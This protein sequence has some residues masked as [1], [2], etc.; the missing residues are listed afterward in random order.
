MKIGILTWESFGKEDMATAFM[1]LGHSV[2]Q[3]PFSD[4]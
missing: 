3:C 1:E 4:D 2:L